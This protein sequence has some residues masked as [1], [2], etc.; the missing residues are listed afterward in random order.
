VGEVCLEI[1]AHHVEVFR[2]H[3][4]FAGPQHW[5]QY[6][7]VPRLQS[8]IG[9]SVTDSRKQ[10]IQAWWRDRNGRSIRELQLEAMDWA[11]EKRKQ[12]LNKALAAAGD[13]KAKAR[14]EA[15]S[16]IGALVSVRDKLKSSKKYLPP[17]EMWP[18]ILRPPANYRQ[19]PWTDTRPGSRK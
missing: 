17:R 4:K 11:I 19:A 13:S 6:N 12:D 18:S 3:I 7:F 2:D 14:Q 5:H 9:D 16:E 15:A 1:I 10:K 8:A